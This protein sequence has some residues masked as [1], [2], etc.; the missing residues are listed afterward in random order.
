MGELQ[1]IQP[2]EEKVFR[3]LSYKKDSSEKDRSLTELVSDANK[4]KAR[5]YFWDNLKFQNYELNFIYG[6]IMGYLLQDFVVKDEKL[7]PDRIINPQDTDKKFLEL[8]SVLAQFDE[9]LKGYKETVKQN[10]SAE[11]NIESKLS[12]AENRLKTVK[13]RLEDAESEN[14]S[15]DNGEIN[16]DAAR[17]KVEIEKYNTEVSDIKEQITRHRKRL[18]FLERE[19]KGFIADSPLK[20]YFDAAFSIAKELDLEST[21]SFEV[22]NTGKSAD[23]TP[24]VNLLQGKIQGVGIELDHYTKPKEDKPSFLSRWKNYIMLGA[25][26]LGLAGVLVY[27]LGSKKVKI[28][29]K[30]VESNISSTPRSNRNNRPSRPIPLDPETS[31]KSKGEKVGY[32]EVVSFDH[33]TMIMEV[34]PPGYTS[35]VNYQLDLEKIGIPSMKYVPGEVRITAFDAKTMQLTV[36]HIPSKEVAVWDLSHLPPSKLDSTW[37]DII[38]TSYKQKG[39]NKFDISKVTEIYGLINT[40]EWGMVTTKGMNNP[41][42]RD[43]SKTEIVDYLK[44][45]ASTYTTYPVAEANIMIKGHKVVDAKYDSMKNILTLFTTQQGFDI[46]LHLQNRVFLSSNDYDNIPEALIYSPENR[47]YFDLSRDSEEVRCI[48]KGER[49]NNI[50]HFFPVPNITPKF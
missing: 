33:E 49:F 21:L 6:N 32:G 17:L 13:K 45:I 9:I 24:D 47:I 8:Y 26:V 11:S 43:V 38:L 25:A 7:F 2:V 30:P 46:P 40:G 14:K 37:P 4:E 31:N 23:Y 28:R 39:S 27:G 34:I 50:L 44:D 3:N 29:D 18:K 36:K 16:H 22:P 10:K 1:V 48:K 15:I 19:L 12:S 42:E 41:S 20:S 5:K 35:S